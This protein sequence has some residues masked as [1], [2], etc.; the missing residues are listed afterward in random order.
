MNTFDADVAAAAKREPRL[1]VVKVL[2]TQRLSSRGPIAA[3]GREQ[4]RFQRQRKVLK[5][6]TSAT[7]GVTAGFRRIRKP[8]HDRGDLRSGSAAWAGD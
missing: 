3:F 4:K 5:I 2:V 8:R 7:L 6:L 1:F